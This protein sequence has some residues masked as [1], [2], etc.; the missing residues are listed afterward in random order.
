M[1]IQTFRNMKGLIHG[2]DP[3][4][5]ECDRDGIL[6]IGDTEIVVSQGGDSILPVLFYGATGDYDATFMDEQGDTYTLDKVKVRQGRIVPPSPT[7]VELMELRVRV[8]M[9]EREIA[10]LSGKTEDLSN[11]FDT[12]SLNFLIG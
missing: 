9:L 4:R 11:I 5:I 12:N 10:I 1:Q 2:K 8:D 7:T 3:K 6:K